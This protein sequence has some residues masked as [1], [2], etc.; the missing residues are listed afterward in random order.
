MKRFLIITAILM[1]ASFAFAGKPD[2][3]P[4]EG[5]SVSTNATPATTDVQTS[6]RVTGYFEGF[7]LDLSGYASPTVDV[8]IVT[9]TAQGG[10]LTTVRTLWSK[11]SVTAD[12]EKYVRTPVVN[13]GDTA[14]SNEGGL[15]PLIGDYIQVKV[16]EALATNAITW[17]AKVYI[18][19]P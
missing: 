7:S 1:V 11:D 2:V 3:I 4:F 14:I 6:D 16:Y 15:I 5:S 10:T 19:R 8:D 17:K 18:R 12:T 13:T 9:V